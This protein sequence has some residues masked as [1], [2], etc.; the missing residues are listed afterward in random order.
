MFIFDFDGV[1]C[2][3]FETVLTAFEQIKGIDPLHGSLLLQKDYLRTLE[4]IQIF[5]FLNVKK[6]Q[7]PMMIIQLRKI[8]KPQ[9]HL[10]KPIH[11][12]SDVLRILRERQIK[13]GIL[14]TNSE[15]NVKKFLVKNQI[16]YF[17]FIYS[18]G[19]LNKATL[20]K[21]IISKENLDPKNV[22]YIG[23]ETRDIAAS[24]KAN[25]RSIAVGWGYNDETALLKHNP[26]YFIKTPMEL[27]AIE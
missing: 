1:I 12:M 7:I 18:A 2:D 26:D 14:S 6:Y 5:E 20:L 8:I 25:V 23:D 21:K 24:R 19:L 10:L 16:D 22:F 9:I 3:S 11:T 13:M 27:L 4:M 17:D 15:E